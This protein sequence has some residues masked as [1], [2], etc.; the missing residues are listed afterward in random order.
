M[1]CKSSTTNNST[2]DSDKDEAAA[3]AAAE[4]A[5]W[6]S[7]T[8]LVS[9]LIA[10]SLNFTNDIITIAFVQ[11]IQQVTMWSVYNDLPDENLHHCSC[12]YFLDDMTNTT[13]K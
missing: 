11:C 8:S 3:A 10:A 12:G 6:L 1:L 9:A 4:A 13:Y 2:S 5:L 7:T